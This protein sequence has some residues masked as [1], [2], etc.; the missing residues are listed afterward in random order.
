M[1]RPIASNTLISQDNISKDNISK[2][3]FTISVLPQE[4][5]VIMN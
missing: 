3:P 5:W 4:N 2:V 1:F